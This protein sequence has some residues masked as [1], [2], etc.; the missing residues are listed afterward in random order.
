MSREQMAAAVGMQVAAGRVVPGMCEAIDVLVRQG[1]PRL[2]GTGG[3]KS[4]G[5]SCSPPARGGLPPSQ[6]EHV[7]LTWCLLGTASPRLTLPFSNKAERLSTRSWGRAGWTSKAPRH[8]GHARSGEAAEFTSPGLGIRSGNWFHQGCP[9][10]CLV[11]YLENAQKTP[12]P[13]GHLGVRQAPCRQRTPAVVAQGAPT[14]A[15]LGLAKA[16]RS[17]GGARALLP[18]PTPAVS[19]SAG[20]AR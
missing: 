4:A 17:G 7:G 6:P 16:S 9:H 13:P 14:R 18:A 3:P 15:A 11:P 19:A 2:V 10:F 20:L 5:H 12:V 8:R 1:G